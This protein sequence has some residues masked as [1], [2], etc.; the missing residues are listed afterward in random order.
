[1][2]KVKQCREVHFGTRDMAGLADPNPAKRISP[3]SLARTQVL[4]EPTVSCIKD[5]SENTC[6]S[7]DSGKS[8]LVLLTVF[9]IFCLYHGA[10]L[11]PLV[12]FV[13]KTN[14]GL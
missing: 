6:I 13:L 3:S 2:E 11:F 12:K 5:I 8:Q 14:T 4:P 10:F 9:L 1:M 7:G